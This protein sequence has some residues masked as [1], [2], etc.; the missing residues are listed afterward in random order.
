MP[1]GWAYAVEFLSRDEETALLQQ[2]RTLP[3]QSA[4]YK[5]WQ[6][7]RRIVS[8]GAR[9]D[10]LRNALDPAPPIPQFLH[11]L[12][13][14]AAHWA[15][16]PAQ[17]LTHAAISEYPLNA[18]LGWHRDVHEF[19]DVIG[20]SLLGHARMRFR[21]YPPAA[22]ARALFAIELAP[23]SIYVMRG[24]VRWHWQHAISPTPE[25]RYSIT[26]RTRAAG[27]A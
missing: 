6:A 12:R 22:P 15:G 4:Q 2:L 16:C 21:P 10:F 24:A 27:A 17:R 26:F 11:P 20:I 8:Y 3:F 25:L 23:R 5:E 7:R 13:Q 18:P 14:R 9:Y 1:D 19:E